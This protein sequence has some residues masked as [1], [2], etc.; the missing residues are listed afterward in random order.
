MRNYFLENIPSHELAMSALDE[1]FPDQHDSTKVVFGPDGCS[2]ISWLYV[3]EPDDP[4]WHAGPF[5]IA[6]DVTG[7][8][9]DFDVDARVIEALRLVQGRSGGVIRDDDGQEI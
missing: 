7:R 8:Q 2:S 5:L 9:Y 4:D 6:A 3:S 1:A